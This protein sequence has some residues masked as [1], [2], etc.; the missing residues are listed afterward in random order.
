MHYKKIFI[1]V[2][3]AT[4]FFGL[5]LTSYLFPESDIYPYGF[6]TPSLND[7]TI[8]AAN[9]NLDAVKAFIAQKS[10]DINEKDRFG[11]TALYKAVINNNLEMADY[12]LAHGAF[13]N[14]E[15]NHYFT[16]LHQAAINGYEDMIKLLVRN[17]A[18]LDNQTDDTGATPLHIALDRNRYTTAEVLL[19]LGANTHIKNYIEKYDALDLAKKYGRDELITLVK[20]YY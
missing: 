3:V 12:L 4:L 15:N 14:S 9:N 5:L 1:V 17:G 13:V 18:E 8:A 20:R 16:P 10:S 7:I 6:V 19:D 11:E 2:T